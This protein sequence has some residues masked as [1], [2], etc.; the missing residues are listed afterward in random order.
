MVLGN[1]PSF[2]LQSAALLREGN[3]LVQGADFA[4]F[5]GDKVV[6]MG[7]NGA[8]KSS[9]VKMLAGF[10]RASQGR[11]LVGGVDAR[12][13]DVRMLRR[14]VSYVSSSLQ[15]RFLGSTTTFEV[16]LT[17]TS[18]DLAPYWRSY[19][20][21]AR[22]VADELLSIFRLSE[23]RDHLFSS[24]S[25]GERQR[26]VLAR[27][28]A[29]RSPLVVADEPFVGLDLVS[30]DE[31]IVALDGVGTLGVRSNTVV[32]VV[33]HTE[34]IPEIFDRVVFVRDSKLIW[35]GSKDEFLTSKVLSEL[36]ET[37]LRVTKLGE[38]CYTS[39]E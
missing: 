34:E 6:V 36:Y 32:L 11:L 17:G 39:V 7:R 2:E 10:E 21:E 1:V 31:L 29:R 20:D 35:Q 28:F 24:L 30:R 22:S 5:E 9:F 37:R 25:Q 14:S 38:R 3:T 33:H 16:V 4:L 13:M 18:G 15:E 19:S 12:S 26:A 8:G 27:A 23:K